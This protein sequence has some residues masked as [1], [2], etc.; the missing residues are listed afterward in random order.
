MSVDLSV[1]PLKPEQTQNI[2]GGVSTGS[3]EDVIKS[4]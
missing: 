2:E 3:G 4:L 1:K